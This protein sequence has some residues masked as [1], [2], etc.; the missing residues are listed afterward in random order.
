MCKSPAD[1]FE[2]AEELCQ[3]AAR[4]PSAV[5]ETLY[6]R[7]KRIQHGNKKIRE[8][9]IF[10]IDEVL[11][12]VDAAPTTSAE[13]NG[14]I[15]GVMDIPVAHPRPEKDHGIVKQRA[16]ALSDVA[17]LAQNIGVLLH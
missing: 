7:A 2:P 6:L 1:A 4:G 11:S 15:T 3:H 16:L 14:Q 12:G 8:R 9:T 5:G 10:R 17:Q 13:D